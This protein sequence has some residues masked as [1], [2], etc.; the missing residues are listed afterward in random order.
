MLKS[1]RKGISKK[2]YPCPKEPVNLIPQ[3]FEQLTF[4]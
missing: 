2:R 1:L 3:G 4:Y